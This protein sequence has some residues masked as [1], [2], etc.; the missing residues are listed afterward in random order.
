MVCAPCWTDTAIRPRYAS[1]NW[2]RRYTAKLA[3]GAGH[4]PDQFV[5]EVVG[6]IT[7]V[8]S[9]LHDD[10]VT[11][12]DELVANVLGEVDSEGLTQLLQVGGVPDEKLWQL[13]MPTQ[14]KRSGYDRIQTLSSFSSGRSLA[15]V[16]I[17]L[18]ATVGVGFAGPAARAVVLGFGLL[19]GEPL[20]KGSSP[21]GDRR[22]LKGVD[23]QAVRHRFV[24]DVDRTPA[25]RDR[26]QSRAG[27]GGDR[28]HRCRASGSGNR[29]RDPPSRG[30]QR[31]SSDRSQAQPGRVRASPPGRT[32]GPSRCACR[33]IT[34]VVDRGDRS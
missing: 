29:H 17:P 4:K 9:D 30:G 12:V 31:R 7:A 19:S 3:Q 23:D 2:R 16:T 15:T 24:S 28:S 25:S 1:A 11:T 20:I 18:L 26:P 34:P 33:R 5:A 8:A 21:D 22:D 6:A 32:R 14:R 27:P 10:T 13:D